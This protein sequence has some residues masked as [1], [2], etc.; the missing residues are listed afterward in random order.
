MSV[1]NK[2][3]VLRVVRFTVFLHI[4][5]LNILRLYVYVASRL[6]LA[7]VHGAIGFTRTEVTFRTKLLLFRVRRFTDKQR[8]FVADCQALTAGDRAVKQ[9]HA[10]IT[11]HSNL[12]READGLKSLLEQNAAGRK[13]WGSAALTL[14]GDG[15]IAGAQGRLM[16]SCRRS[17]SL[18]RLLDT[19]QSSPTFYWDCLLWTFL[20]SSYFEEL[21]GDLA[22]EFTLRSETGGPENALCWYADQ[23][24]RTISDHVWTKLSRLA[25]LGTLIDLVRKNVR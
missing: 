1:L 16:R 9:R 17:E 11:R 3:L 19:V 7:S 4:L 18:R 10:L 8:T 12:L 24:R 5:T 14:V 23:A 20:P 21:I 6:F 2:W 22:E 25:T 15:L 13:A